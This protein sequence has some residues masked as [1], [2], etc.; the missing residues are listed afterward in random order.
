MKFYALSTKGAYQSKNL[1]KLNVSSQKPE[2]SHFDG[3]LLFKSYKVSAK[4]HR[5]QELSFMTLKS[6]V[7]FTVKLAFGVEI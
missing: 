5:V 7:N 6:D 1:V 2:I 3:L 4:K